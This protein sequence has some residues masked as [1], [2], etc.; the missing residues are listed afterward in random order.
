ME[1]KVLSFPTVW[2]QEN[3]VTSCAAF[4]PAALQDVCV[5]V[6]DLRP[7]MKLNNRLTLTSVKKNLN[8]FK[9]MK[10]SY[11]LSFL[12]TYIILFYPAYFLF[13]NQL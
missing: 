5:Y 4:G 3:K 10:T 2:K 7:A 13:C 8:L 6:E 9:K 12:P 11:N 1:K